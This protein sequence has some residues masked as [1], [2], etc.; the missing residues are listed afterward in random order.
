MQ[1]WAVSHAG[2]REGKSGCSNTAAVW[3]RLLASVDMREDVRFYILNALIGSTS[4][5]CRVAKIGFHQVIHTV[6]IK[7]QH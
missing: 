2:E 3:P 7:L 5:V 1:C 4:P 6:C